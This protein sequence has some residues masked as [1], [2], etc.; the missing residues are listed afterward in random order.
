MLFN[1]PY[2]IF[3]IFIRQSLTA[4]F[5]EDLYKK[6]TKACL[7]NQI[8]KIW[9]LLLVYEIRLHAV[10]FGN[11]WM[12]KNSEDSQNCQRK[13]FEF[14]VII[15]SKLDKLVVL[16]CIN[17]IAGQLIQ[18]F[19]SLVFNA[20][21]PFKQ[22]RQEAKTTH[23]QHKTTF[24]SNKK[25]KVFAN[26]L[27]SATKTFFG[28]LSQGLCIDWLVCTAYSFFQHLIGSDQLSYIS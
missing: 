11:N 2:I 14:N 13:F 22:P 24:Y 26:K 8:S 1:V 16:L 3:I 23:Q 25:P 21:F 7:Q 15:T 17:Y 19:I 10:Q 6:T 5:I 28:V 4:K 12:R 18:T 20:H 27:L 9:V